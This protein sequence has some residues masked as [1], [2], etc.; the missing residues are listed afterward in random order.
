MGPV[1]RAV[2]SEAQRPSAGLT[3]SK[4]CSEAGT[5]AG[6][7]RQCGLPA[8][9]PV[10]YALPG[11]L[12]SALPAGRRMIKPAI[13][14]VQADLLRQLP[15]LL[16]TAHDAEGQAWASALVGSPG[17]LSAAPDPSLL[18]ISKA[19]LLGDGKPGAHPKPACQRPPAIHAGAAN[20]R[21]AFNPAWP[22]PACPRCRPAGTASRAAG[23]LPGHPAQQQAA[24]ARQ[25]HCGG[26]G[27]W[28][29]GAAR[30]EGP[31]AAGLQQLPQV[32]P[33][34]RWASS[35]VAVQWPVLHVLCNVC[36]Q[37]AV[38]CMPRR[39]ARRDARR[40]PLPSRTVTRRI[41]ASS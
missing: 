10:S 13:N 35:R 31:G 8:Q 20:H 32:H 24:R 6:V 21:A 5:A 33:G 37:Q 41:P 7:G 38:C 11:L 9:A 29:R 15:L 26:R 1:G 39:N 34:K 36:A 23:G 28:P 18:T 27:A 4:S 25:R 22:W 3:G 12:C 30:A 2:V 16:V 17:F 40:G 14:T 19:R